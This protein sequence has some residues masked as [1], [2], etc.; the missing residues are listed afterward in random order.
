VSAKATR[1]PIV[2]VSEPEEVVEAISTWSTAIVH[3]QHIGFGSSQKTGEVWPV[4][5]QA[6]GLLAATIAN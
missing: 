5:G 6:M 3:E 4:T 2:V 1:L